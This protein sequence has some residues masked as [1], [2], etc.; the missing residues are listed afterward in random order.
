MIKNIVFDIG[1]VLAAFCWKQYISELGIDPQLEDRLA[2]A[3]TCNRLW[4]EIDHGVMPLDDIIT[5]MIA[6][7]PE[8][9]NEIRLF[10]RDRRRL[11]LEYD[12]SEGWLKELKAEGYGIYLLSNYSEDHFRYIS[13]TFRFFGLEDGMVISY[14]EKC[15]K[16]ERRIYEILFERYGLKPEECVFLDDSPENIKGAI[17]AGMH[18]IVFTGYEQGRSDLEKLLTEQR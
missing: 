4:R 10:F 18:G 7:D 13:Q 1:N 3:T 5:A 16:P 9:E 17:E 11:V 6:T 14:R 12:Y 2:K 8:I 15:L